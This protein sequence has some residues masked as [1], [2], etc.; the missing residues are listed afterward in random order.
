MKH[1]NLSRKPK[2]VQINPKIFQERYQKLPENQGN[3]LSQTG[4][5]FLEISPPDM[6]WSGARTSGQV[7]FPI[8]FRNVQ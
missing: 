1:L 2:T 3:L 4:F 7:Y 5:N 8:L 6:L